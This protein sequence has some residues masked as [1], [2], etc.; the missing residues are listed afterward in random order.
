MDLLI[1]G[2]FQTFLFF[3]VSGYKETY[4]S[5]VY[6][7]NRED[8]LDASILFRCVIMECMIYFSGDSRFV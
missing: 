4:L 7:Y 3:L 8:F 1:S 5:L 2:C 6:Q